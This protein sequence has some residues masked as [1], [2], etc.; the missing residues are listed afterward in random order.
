LAKE[1]RLSGAGWREYLRWQGQFWFVNPDQ[2]WPFFY[3]GEKSPKMGG[4]KIA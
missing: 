2:D 1:P 4:K 3:Y